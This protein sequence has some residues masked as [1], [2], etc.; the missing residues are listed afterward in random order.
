MRNGELLQSLSFFL[1]MT[2]PFSRMWKICLKID[3]GVCGPEYEGSLF[4]Q[5]LSKFPEQVPYS[6]RESILI[7]V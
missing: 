1:I 3:T 2:V 6:L 4:L 5:M 7:F